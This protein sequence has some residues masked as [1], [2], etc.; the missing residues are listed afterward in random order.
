MHI[1]VDFFYENRWFFI[2]LGII[3]G[4]YFLLRLI[5]NQIYLLLIKRFQNKYSS[6]ETHSLRFVKRILNTLWL[7]L[8]VIVIFLLVVEGDKQARL[9]RNFQMAIYLGVI[10]VATIVLASSVNLWFKNAIKNKITHK[11]D[12]TTLLF[13]RRFIV[14]GIYFIGILVGLATIPSM[15]TIATTALGGAGVIAVIAGIASQEALGNIVSGIFI[16]I[17]RPFRVGQTV[18][19]SE[20]MQGVVEE[21]TLRHTVIRNYENKMILV[22]N[23]IINKERLIN[24][25]LIDSKCCERIEIGISYDSDIAL[26]KQIMREECENH[27]N[28]LDNRSFTDREIGKPLVR[29]AVISLDDSSVVIRAWAWARTSSEAYQLRYDVLESIKIRFDDEGIEIPFPY[30]TVVFKNDDSS[31]NNNSSEKP[32]EVN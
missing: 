5:T 23:A 19:I 10:A 14:Y 13:L 17:F 29:T 30:R 27:P 12:S 24:Y 3:I 2:Y 4:A 18:K 6:N 16:I 25:D 11:E 9:E 32:A 31:G 26:A 8:G 1:M 15:R 20:G 28:I 22:P 21:I 7:V